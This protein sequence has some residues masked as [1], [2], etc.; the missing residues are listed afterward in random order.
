[1]RSR[2]H[3]SRPSRQTKL[4][5]SIRQAHAVARESGLSY[6]ATGVAA[7]ISILRSGRA[8]SRLWPECSRGCEQRAQVPEH[9][10]PSARFCSEKD[11]GLNLLP[12]ITRSAPRLALVR[13]QDITPDRSCR[14][15]P[16]RLC[17]TVQRCASSL[18]TSATT[19]AAS[20][21]IIIRWNSQVVLPS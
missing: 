8:P 21:P 10:T 20:W 4:E 19:S 2:V 12:V 7:R 9:I 18:A 14:L 17:R 1:M 5:E 11:S 16:R 13:G 3:C 6:I 15:S